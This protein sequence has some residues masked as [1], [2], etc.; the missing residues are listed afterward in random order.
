MHVALAGRRRQHQAT[1][2]GLS[3]FKVCALLPISLTPAPSRQGSNR[4]GR[5]DDGFHRRHRA[6]PSCRGGGEQRARPDR[7]DGRRRSRC[8]RSCTRCG[9]ARRFEPVVVTTGQH[10]DLVAPIL[11]LAGIEP[12]DD[13][14]VGR[15][16][17]TLNDLVPSVIGRLDE[18]CRERFGATGAAVRRVSRSA[19]DGFPA[20]TLVHG[21]TSSALAAALASFHLRIPVCHVEAGL[22]TWST[23][24]PVP[25]GAQ[26]TADLPD[27]GV[28]SGADL[29]ERGEP[30]S[31][32][33]P[34]RADL[35]HGQH[36]H[37]CAAVRRQRS[38]SRS[39]IRPSPRRWS[40]S[41][42]LVVVTAHRRENWNGGLA[43]IA[44]AVG[45]LATVASRARFVV[46]A[47]SEPA[48]PRELGDPLA[49]HPER[50]PAPSRSPTRSSPA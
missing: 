28:P 50:D 36:R 17:L 6:P 5:H 45:R 8:S 43:R 1:I 25:G 2:D 7:D 34:P 42:P 23:L 19:A 40:P 16:G 15:P 13:L 31:R 47:A 46:A 26:S 39:R 24:T 9:G 10:R 32:G 12:D 33:R 21:D 38:T 44:E 35:R 20:A 3:G 49:A 48:R 30:R 27:R 11:E 22:R 14:D 37:R 29:G 41:A 18:F 4:A